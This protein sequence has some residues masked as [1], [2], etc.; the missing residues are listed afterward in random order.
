MSTYDYIVVGAGSAGCVLAAKLSEGGRHS[1]L[2]LE[3]GPDDRS[4][5]IH[6]PKGFGK[7][8]SD[9]KHVWYFPTEPEPSTADKSQVWLRGKVLGGSSA[10]NGMV[11]MRGHPDDYDEWERN[12]LKG[13]GWATM[14]GYFAAMENHAHGAGPHRGSGGPLG[15]TP[16]P[17]RYPFG[18]AVLEAGRS[19][20]LPVRDDINHPEQEGIAYLT[21]NIRHGRR[22]SAAV[23]YLT[24]DVRRRSNL[25]IVTDALVQRVVM[26]GTRATGV[27]VSRG[28]QDQQFQATRE[29]IVSAGALNSPKL[30]NLSGIGAAPHLRSLGIDVRIDSPDVG[31]NM[32][33]HLLSW[34]QY[35]LKDGSDCVNSA[36]AGWPLFLNTVRYMLFRK[37]IL[38]TGSTEI[39]GFVRTNP[40]LNRPDAQIMVDPYSLDLDSPTM[41]FDRRPGMQA[42]VYPLRP[43]SRGSVVAR[44]ANPEDPPLIHPNYL[45]TEHDR[46][47]V[48]GAF[49]FARRLFAQPALSRFV[50]EEKFPG[51]QVQTD[52]EILDL[53]KRRGQSG[54]HAMGTCRMSTD[55][56]SVLDERLR[57]RG[58]TGLR[59]V[60]L[61]V[62]PAPI[63]GN[64]NA[65]TM[66]I[67]ARAS[68][69]ILEDARAA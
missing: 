25:T 16:C 9:P 57:V 59:V 47:T 51:S 21:H 34:L 48:I 50:G 11:Y 13:W 62:V 40:G 10:V 7:L 18:D 22:Q 2:L 45:A 8:L 28:G 24:R 39:G 12:G 56:G 20:G 35:W 23:A 60:D 54:Y 61:S 65:P 29:V 27:T 46:T 4:P 58:A 52:D 37:G 30:L 49:R 17:R 3:A 64:T 38:A 32:H 26:D 55:P 69:L 14:S 43:D 41:G 66:A 67:A 15:V 63:S 36:F 42:F 44:S 53:F 1:V 33:E 6:M 19:L 31:Q 68:D 5:L